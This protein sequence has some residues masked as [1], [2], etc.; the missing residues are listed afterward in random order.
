[1]QRS[2][3]K[4][5]HLVR[6]RGFYP[7]STDFTSTRITST[8]EA[9]FEEIMIL[10]GET[11]DVVSWPLHNA[12]HT[13]DDV[14]SLIIAHQDAINMP[15]SCG[16]TPFDTA[17]GAHAHVAMKALICHGANINYINEISGNTALHKAML[18][19]CKECVGILLDANCDVGIYNNGGFLPFTIYL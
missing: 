7:P 18:V 14:H 19:L 4:V 5:I 2:S 12:I 6:S 9:L 10:S 13:T 3:I 16:L 17:V 11:D 15:D 1:M 8:R